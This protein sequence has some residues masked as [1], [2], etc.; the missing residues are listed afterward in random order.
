[1]GRKHK[2]AVRKSRGVPSCDV[3]V[4]AGGPQKPA[5]LCVSTGAL[6][7]PRIGTGEKCCAHMRSMSVTLEVS[8]SEMSWLNLAASK[9]LQGC[10]SGLVH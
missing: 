3:L 1:M 8:H 5:R 10:V 2:V 6:A 9:N 4:E 7:R